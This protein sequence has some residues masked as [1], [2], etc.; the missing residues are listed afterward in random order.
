MEK[1]FDLQ[2]P[3][4][5]RDRLIVALD[6]AKRDEAKKVV[7]GLKESVSFFKV[8]Y[9]LFF[10]EGMSFVRELVDEGKRV[11]LDLKMDDIGE[12]ITLAVRE[13]A[14]NEVKF[15][16]VFG[17]GATVQAAKS[18][19]GDAPHPKILQ[20][21]ALTSIDEKD[22]RELGFIGPD[23]PLKTIDDYVNWRAKK[24]MDVQCDGLIAAGPS[25]AALHAQYPQAIIVTPGVRPAGTGTDDHKRPTT[26][27][28]AIAAGATYLVV[29]RPIRDAKDPLQ[30][31]DQI[32]EEIRQGLADRQHRSVSGVR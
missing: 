10:A 7:E 18:G 24:S 15:L 19:R 20:I 14:K 13:V 9:Q 16:T 21:T 31:A 26:P 4:D 28:G 2:N 17:N 11:F 25:V 12:T 22:L 6:V 3:T 23:R 32:I 8:G 1:N 27:R 30:V 29:G 5:P